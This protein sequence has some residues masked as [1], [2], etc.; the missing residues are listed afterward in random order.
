M[1]SPQQAYTHRQYG[2]RA[3]SNNVIEQTALLYQLLLDDL[4]QCRGCIERGDWGGRTEKINHATTVLITLGE[5]AEDMAP[6]TQSLS[7]LLSELYGHCLFLISKIV[8]EKHP[9]NNIS[10]LNEAWSMINHVKSSWDELAR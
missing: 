3:Q 7:G 2:Y 1:K 4:D 8:L 5:L 9:E 10:F 6:T